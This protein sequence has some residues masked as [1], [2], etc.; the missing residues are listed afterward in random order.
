MPRTRRV[1]W[2]T[3]F[4]AFQPYTLFLV[5]RVRDAKSHATDVLG[6]GGPGE[7]IKDEEKSNEGME[8]E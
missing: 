1:W 5:N 3:L 8:E 7:K 6:N 2:M 4:S